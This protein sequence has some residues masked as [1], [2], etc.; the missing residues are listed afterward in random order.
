VRL[1]ATFENG[2]ALYRTVCDRGL[3]GIVA[4]RERD[5]YRPG[6]RQWVKTKNLETARLA[7]GARRGGPASGQV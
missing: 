2:Q 4:K 5:A 6:E 1:I 3:E 7:E